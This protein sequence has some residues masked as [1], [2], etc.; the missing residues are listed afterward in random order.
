MTSTHV[1][2]GDALLTLAFQVLAELPVGA[3]RKSRLIAELATASGTVGGLLIFS[4]VIPRLLYSL[5]ER[6]RHAFVT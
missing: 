3:E 2:A 6:R 1:L 5:D 4:V